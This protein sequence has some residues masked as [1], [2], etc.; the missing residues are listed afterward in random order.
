VLQREPENVAAIAGIARLHFDLG[1][2]EAAKRFL[3]MTPQGKEHDPAIKA[4]RAAIEL[5]EQAA[6]L[7]DVADLEQRVA[8]DPDDHQARFDLA[9]ALNA[10]DR[11]VEAAQQLVE[12]V[13]RDR[14]WNEDGARKQL[15]QFFE[16][17]GPKDE[18]SIL[19]RRKLSAVLFS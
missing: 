1:D 11:R 13:K 6:E 18:A 3:A 19:G 10:A 8:A 17:W 7:D 12:I 14:A 9:L 2:I 5:S 16:A 15:L 4:V